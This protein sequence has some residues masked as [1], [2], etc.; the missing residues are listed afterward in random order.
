MTKQVKD[1]CYYNIYTS[2]L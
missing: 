1:K 2:Y